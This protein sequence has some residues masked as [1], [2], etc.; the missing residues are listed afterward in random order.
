MAE[1]E[2]EN[3]KTGGNG[4]SNGNGGNGKNE[5]NGENISI[6]QR[7]SNLFPYLPQIAMCVVGIITIAAIAGII[8]GG[9]LSSIGDG[10]SNV[11]RGLITFLVAIVTVAIAIIL[12]LSAVMSSSNDYKERFALGKE[13]LTIFIGVLGTIVGFYFGSAQIEKAAANQDN[14]NI[15]N[16]SNSNTNLNSANSTNSNSNSNSVQTQ[17]QQAA[18]FE[19]KGFS[20]IIAQDFEGASQ[21][22][23]EAYQKWG[24]YHNVDEIN[25][26]LQKQKSKF[27]QSDTAQKNV[28]WKEIYCGIAKDYEWG[29]PDDVLS[30]FKQKLKSQNYVCSQPQKS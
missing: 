9:K 11:A 24:N 4:G 14:A 6:L 19:Q 15:T 29:M 17:K 2:N 26:L 27:S 30:Q 3:E 25:Q 16:T 28:G 12:T 13:V 21:S 20:A 10:S 1:K 7:L 8:Y 22:F 23:Q 18:D 5:E